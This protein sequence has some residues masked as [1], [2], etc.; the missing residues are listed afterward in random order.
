[1]PS[2][3]FLRSPAGV[4]SSGLD[5]SGIL[6]RFIDVLP[7]T[8]GALVRQMPPIERLPV[9]IETFPAPDSLL[10]SLGNPVGASDAYTRLFTL[11][12]RIWVYFVQQAVDSE[13]ALPTEFAPPTPGSES[14]LRRGLGLL[15]LSLVCPV[16]QFLLRRSRSIIRRTISAFVIESVPTRQSSATLP[17]LALSPPS[18]ATRSVFSSTSFA[19]RTSLSFMANR[20]IMRSPLCRTSLP[21]RRQTPSLVLTPPWNIPNSASPAVPTPFPFFDVL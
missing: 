12:I 11:F 10:D 1:M 5:R 19:T 16:V 4:A 21:A 17:P 9:L 3:P 15:I 6:D 18:P 14:G 13:F 7:P 2:S 20:P 8:L